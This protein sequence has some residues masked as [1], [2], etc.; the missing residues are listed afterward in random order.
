MSVL[1]IDDGI[2]VGTIIRLVGSPTVTPGFTRSNLVQESLA[3]YPIP[4]ENWRVH[5]AFGTL[6]PATPATDDAG[7]V[8]ATFGTGV[9]SI[10]TGDLKAA[11]ATTR[12]AR[13]TVALPIEYEAATDVVLRLRAGM[14]TTI[15][16]TT[17]QIDAEVYLSDE[18]GLVDGA[19]LCA[20]AIQSINSTVLSDKDF[21]ITATTLV[22]GSRLDIRVALSVNDAA[23]GTAVTG[24]L[25]GASLL[26]DV[27]G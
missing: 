19:D 2:Q 20:T 10:Q 16:D 6:L 25:G 21:V 14:F 8:G 23:T 26:C 18:E 9:P 12:Y 1:K 7:L 27:R 5:D 11:G 24:V 13:V 17:A 4:W 15:S 3:K 22:P